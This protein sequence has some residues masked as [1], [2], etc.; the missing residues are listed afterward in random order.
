VSLMYLVNNRPYICLVV[1]NL[2]RFMVELRH[3]HWITPKHALRYLR[4]TMEYGL[5]YL[6]GYEVELQGYTDSDWERSAVDKMITL[7]CCFSLGLAVITWFNK[8]HNSIALGSTKAEYMAT[9]MASH[10]SIWLHKFLACLFDQ[11][12]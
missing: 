2:S 10:E 9:S 7:G 4:G 5:R 3:M 8:K 1:N 6:G 12:L 11:E